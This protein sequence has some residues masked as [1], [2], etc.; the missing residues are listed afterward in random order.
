M[1]D[2]DED[3]GVSGIT[4]FNRRL[5]KAR[6]SY[7]MNHRWVTTITWELPVGKGKK[8]MNVTGWRNAVF[9]GWE[10]MGSQHFQSGPPMTVTFAGSPNRYLPG[11]SRPIQIKPND[12]VKLA[13][14]D[15]GG[16]SIPIFG[17]EPVHQRRWIHLS[18]GLH[19]R[20]A[21]PKHAAGA[22]LGLDAGLAG[23][24]VSDRG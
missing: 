22:R 6:A 5:E 16:E 7:D 3:G 10:L 19:C 1:N 17:A 18:G 23:Q 8:Y 14:V 15:V 24:R 20:N 21:R 2:V 12:E 13:H 11:A 9:G 4:F